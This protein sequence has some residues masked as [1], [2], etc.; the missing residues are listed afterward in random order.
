MPKEDTAT[1]ARSPEPKTM[2][3]IFTAIRTVYEF[4][5]GGS[6]SDSIKR[7][8]GDE[9]TTNFSGS[10][11]FSQVQ[12]PSV[13]A[14]SALALS[15]SDPADGASAVV[16]SKKPK[17]VFNNALVAGAPA[18][19]MLLKASDASKV[20]ATI[21]LGGANKEITIT[22]SGNLTASTNYIISFAVTD[23]YG[24]TLSGAVDFATAA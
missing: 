23:I 7:V 10:A 15:S 21:A 24:Q 19:V 12:V 5:L 8:I 3:L 6:K 4:S 1:R 2:E 18:G 16:V 11:W 22:P 17:L 14:P 20:T 9:D 13:V